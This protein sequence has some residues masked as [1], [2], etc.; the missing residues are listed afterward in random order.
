VL[1]VHLDVDLVHVILLATAVL[2]GPA[3]PFIHLPLLLHHFWLLHYFELLVLLLPI[4]AAGLEYHLL[5]AVLANSQL[6]GNGRV[7]SSCLQFCR[8]SLQA[9]L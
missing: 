5:L 2:G 9:R 3:K 8:S 7:K 4:A 1:L 6:Q